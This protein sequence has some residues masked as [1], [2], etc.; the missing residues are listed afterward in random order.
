MGAEIGF[1]TESELLAAR[2]ITVESRWRDREPRL[3][4]AFFLT[5]PSNRVRFGMR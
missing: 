1:L 4:G 3:Y 2:T 5:T